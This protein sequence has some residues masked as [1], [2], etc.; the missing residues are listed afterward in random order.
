MPNNSWFKTLFFVLALSGSIIMHAQSSGTSSNTGTSGVSLGPGYDTDHILSAMYN[1][2]SDLVIVAAHRGLHSI[3]DDNGNACC[4]TT[5]PNS[6]IKLDFSK[7]PEN[8]LQSI[9]NAALMGIEAIELDVRLTQDGVPILTHD[10]TWGR[11]TN[12]GNADGKCCFDPWGPGP[13]LS[14]PD[15]D[16]GEL[17]GGVSNVGGQEAAGLNPN[18][19]GWSNASVQDTLKLRTSTNFA[20]STWNEAPPTLQAAI[21]YIGHNNIQAVFTLDVKDGTSLQAVWKL[22]AQTGF[23]RVAILK[24]DAAYTYM[25]PATL[26]SDFNKLMYVTKNSSDPDSNYVKVMPVYQTSGIAPGRF[27]SEPREL[28]S[29]QAYNAFPFTAG[30]EVDLKQNPGILTSLYNWGDS[31]TPRALANFNPY[32]EWVASGADQTNYV[33]YQFFNSNGYCCSFLSQYFY[34]GAPNGQPSDTADQR[35]DWSFILANRNGFNFITTDNPLAMGSYLWQ[36][37]QRNTSYFF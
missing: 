17:G 8:S 36:R 32:K 9:Y 28:A 25:W 24:Y 33:N 1:R 31:G 26:Q 22:I 14:V 13:G 12:V 15:G 5:L 10:S 4:V 27:G 3:L 2:H 6:S 35:P 11:E 21:D 37:G 16:P 23:Y 7:T 34:N 18:V 20:W 29:M 30:M 19:S